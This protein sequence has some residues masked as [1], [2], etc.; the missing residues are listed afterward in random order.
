MQSLKLYL[1]EAP[2]APTEK[3]HLLVH[4]DVLELVN[5][6]HLVVVWVTFIVSGETVKVTSSTNNTVIV[7]GETVKVTSSTNNTVI[8]SGETVKVTSSTNNTNLNATESE[9]FY[10]LLLYL[11]DKTEMTHFMLGFLH[12]ILIF[13]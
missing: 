5:A 11:M 12:I 13:R 1:C 10:C 4:C 8:V 6:C 3:W 7:S 2:L 9:L